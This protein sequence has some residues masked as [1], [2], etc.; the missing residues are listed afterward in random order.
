MSNHK[1][2]ENGEFLLDISPNT[3]DW[4][5]VYIYD[6]TLYFNAWKGRERSVYEKRI[7]FTIKGNLYTIHVIDGY[8]ILNEESA[9]HYASEWYKGNGTYYRLD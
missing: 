3:K 4:G 9:K 8:S 2:N 7:S 5:H 6:L 1:P